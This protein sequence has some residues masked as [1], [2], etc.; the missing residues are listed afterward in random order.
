MSSHGFESFDLR[1]KIFE[2]VLQE[3]LA[4]V[5]I[6]RPFKLTWMPGVLLITFNDIFAPMHLSIGLAW[7]AD[8]VVSQ[9]LDL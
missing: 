4:F 2:T 6:Q 9:T 1:K 5:S 8:F 3:P 7:R